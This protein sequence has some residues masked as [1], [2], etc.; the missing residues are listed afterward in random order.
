VSAL[1]YSQG[2]LS[3]KTLDALSPLRPLLAGY[4]DANRKDRLTAVS[5]K[6]SPIFFIDQATAAAFRFQCQPGKP[7]Q[8]QQFA[9]QIIVLPISRCLSAAASRF[10]WMFPDLSCWLCMLFLHGLLLLFRIFQFLH[11]VLNLEFIRS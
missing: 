2:L 5:P 3:G 6:S 7:K 8:R 11:C 4:N 9:R 10:F 1:P